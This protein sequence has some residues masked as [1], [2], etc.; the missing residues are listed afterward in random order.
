MHPDFVKHTPDQFPG[1]ADHAGQAVG[2]KT[3]GIAPKQKKGY[4]PFLDGKPAIVLAVP[5]LML[6]YSWHPEHP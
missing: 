2:R 5:V 6:K 4:D 3:L 1:Y